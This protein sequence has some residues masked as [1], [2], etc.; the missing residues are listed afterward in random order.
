MGTASYCMPASRARITACARSATWS[1]PQ[2]LATWLRTRLETQH[3]RIRDLLVRL[4]ARDHGWFQSTS[5][6]AR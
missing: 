6:A 2:M 5:M 1:V 4:A 3:Q